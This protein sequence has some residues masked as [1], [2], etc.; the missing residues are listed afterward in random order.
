MKKKQKMYLWIFLAVVLVGLAI[1]TVVDISSNS[2]QFQ[3]GLSSG[4]NG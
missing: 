2:A 1:V 4:W 3:D